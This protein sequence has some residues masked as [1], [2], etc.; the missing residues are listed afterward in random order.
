MQPGVTLDWFIGQLAEALLEKME[1]RE[2]GLVSQRDRR[3]LMGR[4]HIDAVR[5]RM[6]DELAAGVEVKTAFHRG[7]DYLLTPSAVRDELARLSTRAP[8]A[9]PTA[10]ARTGR[11]G[12]SRAAAAERKRSDRDEA[13]SVRRE[14]ES[15]MRRAQRE[16]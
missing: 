4:R 7:R 1:A 11:R 14:L 8:A 5:R 10:P 12:S 16:G 9:A 15:E 6:A 3:G 13:A 2:S